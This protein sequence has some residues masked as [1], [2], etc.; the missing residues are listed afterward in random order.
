MLFNSQEFLL[1]FLPVV[2]AIFHLLQYQFN[3]RIALSFLV[4]GSLVFYGYWKPIYLALILASALA[5]FLIGHWIAHFNE[6]SRQSKILLWF[7]I[8]LNLAALGFFK[9]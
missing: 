4:L 1:L 6:G 5:N 2:L 8:V 3:P 7:G 9:Y